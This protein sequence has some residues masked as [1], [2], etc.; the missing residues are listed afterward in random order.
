MVLA[1]SCKGPPAELGDDCDLH[2]DC[3]R[4]LQCREGSC[5]ERGKDGDPCGPGKLCARPL[6]CSAK[7]LCRT[8]EAAAEEARLAR[9]DRERELLLKSGVKPARIDEEQA[10]IEAPAAAQAGGSP[11]RVVVVESTG[12][13][14]A[15]CRSDERLIGGTC[16]IDGASGFA[17]QPAGYGKDDTVGARWTCD[18]PRKKKTTSTALCQRV[19]AT[20]PK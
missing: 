15:A 17:S 20:A 7:R 4:H 19:G 18:A 10:S 16:K 14:F 3:E 1:G 2:R 11:V 8:W 6:H 5:A 13:G 9:A 12:P